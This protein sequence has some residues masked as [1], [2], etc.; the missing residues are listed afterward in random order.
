[1]SA[2]TKTRK[3][4]AF[5]LDDPRVRIAAADRPA[6]ETAVPV[7]IVPEREL[8]LPAAVAAPEPARRS[9]MRWGMVFWAASGGLVLLGLCIAVVTLIEDLFSRS[10][11]LGVVGLALA[12]IAA[13]ALSVIAVREGIALLRLASVDA[14]RQRAA[15]TLASDD[16]AEGQ[17]VV[18]ELLRLTR[19]IPRLARGRA[20]LD[21]H[22][23]DIIDGRDRVQLAEREL[24]T[25]LDAEARSLIAAAAKRVSVVTAVSPRAAIDM[26]FV[27]INA[28]GLIRRLAG[29]YGARPGMLGSLRLVRHV[30]S[31]LALTGGLA[32]TDSLIQQVVGHG[33]A[34]KLS[35]RLGEGVLNGLLTARLGFVAM[36]VTRPLPFSALPRP[37]LNDLAGSLLRSAQPKASAE[38]AGPAA[39]P[40]AG[41]P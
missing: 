24:M 7:T 19:R 13:L 30:I 18:A 38:I 32:A 29:L 9:R 20:R 35:A 40:G 33:V 37:S 36:D 17:A 28:L 16:R 22:R 10:Q 11:A 5:S 3:P 34:A 2:P 21:D 26:L 6:P 1:M 12:A 31:H 15:A 39:K 14:L 4:A 41:A 27:L 23:A 25:P 8:E